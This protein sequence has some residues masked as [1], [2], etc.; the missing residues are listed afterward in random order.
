MPLSP[1]FA[2]L[3]LKDFD[4]NIEANEYKM[5]RYADDLIIFTDSHS[6]CLEIHEFCKNLLNTLELR[7]PEPGHDSKTKIYRPDETAEFLGVGL[8]R[9][10]ETY[11]TCPPISGPL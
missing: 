9:A 11:V 7:I 5:I 1:F 10:G 3:I 4:K 8:V 2:N 6:E